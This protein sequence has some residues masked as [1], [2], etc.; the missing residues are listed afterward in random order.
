MI[1]K[2]RALKIEVEA[3]EQPLDSDIPENL[4]MQA[5]YLTAPQVENA[6]RSLNT[7][8]GMRQSNERRTSCWSCTNRI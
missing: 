5:I 7:T 8:N 2:L 6:R 3:I 1:S 4:M